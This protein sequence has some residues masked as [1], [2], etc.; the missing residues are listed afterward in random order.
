MIK[1]FFTNSSSMILSFLRSCYI[2]SRMYIHIQMEFEYL[3]DSFRVSV[4]SS[5]WGLLWCW[6]GVQFE[7]QYEVLFEVCFGAFLITNQ[8]IIFQILGLFCKK[9][10][11]K[12][13]TFNIRKTF[14][15]QKHRD[16]FLVV[17]VTHLNWHC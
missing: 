11:T 12:A 9:Y 7:V 8:M 13:C 16:I 3:V 15:S 14:L 5:V 4:W 6:V 10:I 17:N 1:G 2:L